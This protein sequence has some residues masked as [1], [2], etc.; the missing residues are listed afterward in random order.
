MQMY[1]KVERFAVDPIDRAVLGLVILDTY[2][3]LSGPRIWASGA[4]LW[5]N[6]QA[7]MPKVEWIWGSSSVN[8]ETAIWFY[9]RKLD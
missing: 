6:H 4:G 3:F 2:S 7:R 1:A 8:F 9:Y 5:K